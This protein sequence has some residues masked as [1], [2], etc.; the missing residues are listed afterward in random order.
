[1]VF[2]IRHGG[3][4]IAVVVIRRLVGN[5]YS[6]LRQLRL[7]VSVQENG[8]S[9]PSRLGSRRA[10]VRRKIFWE[11]CS[12]TVHRPGTRRQVANRRRQQLQRKQEGQQQQ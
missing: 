8:K 5:K 3:R 4:N 2:A 9:F 10:V 7:Q 11:Y 1:M 12:E 6:R